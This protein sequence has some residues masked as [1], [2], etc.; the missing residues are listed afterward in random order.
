MSRLQEATAPCI[1]AELNFIK[2]APAEP[3]PQPA[4]H[5]TSDSVGN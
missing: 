3:S 1:V 2:G 4:G 5:I